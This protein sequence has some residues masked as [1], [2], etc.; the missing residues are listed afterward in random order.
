LTA[1]KKWSFLFFRFWIML[2]CLTLYNWI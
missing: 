2:T 1:F